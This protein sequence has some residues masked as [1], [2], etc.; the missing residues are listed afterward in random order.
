MHHKKEIGVIGLAVM[1][2]NLALNIESKG[3]SAAVY[4]RTA[5]RTQQFIEEKAQSRDII[6]VYSFKE[7]SERL[8]S[9]KKILL[10][11]KAGSPVDSAIN[12]LL[13]Y[14]EAGDI[15]IDGG[16][17]HFN[18]TR[19]RFEMLREKSIGFI[20]AGISGGEEGAL[21]GPSIMPGG[22][23]EDYAEVEDI[24]T[25][26]AAKVDNEP[27]CAYMGRKD[28]GHFVKM[29][30]NGIEYAHMQLIA[31]VFHFM[32]CRLSMGYNEIAHCFASWGEDVLSSYLLDI[33]VKILRTADPYT[34][35]PV[36]DV[37]LDSAAQKGTGQW[38]SQEALNLGVPL[39]V[40]DAAVFARNISAMKPERVKASEIIKLNTKPFT[41]DKKLLIK[42]AEDALLCGKITAYA[43]GMT[44]LQQASKEYDYGLQLDKTAQIWKGGCIIKAYILEPIRQAFENSPSLSSLLLDEYFLNIIKER[45]HN[46]R[47][48]TAES[49]IGGIPCP[50]SSAA[51]CYFDS[52]R[53]A[54][55][56]AN[57]IQAQ[58]DYF[59]AHTFQRTDKQGSFHF[60][61][62]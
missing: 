12:Q 16:N 8:K 45:H 3:F 57:L 34:H 18:D 32:R 30:H 10:M 15:I 43:Q 14:L 42:A 53:S 28:A 56:P 22:N 5:E 27:C 41:G 25:K 7:L 26:I 33:T 59:G 47:L 48:F 1:G 35:Q 29:V 61:W 6:P 24:L 20:G 38:T 21:K 46:W 9:P 44:L 62:G 11:V 52:Y 60:K 36:L 23:I 4:N 39:S 51:L 17:S 19:R 37:I 49:I 2:Q 54:R 55:L 40:I 13:P 58:R 50:A 31:E